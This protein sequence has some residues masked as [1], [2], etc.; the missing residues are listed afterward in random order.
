[1]DNLD[2]LAKTR[3]R[4]IKVI[5]S[6]KERMCDQYLPDAVSAELRSVILDNVNE[7]CDLAFD[8]IEAERPNPGVVFNE[9][10]LEKLEEMLDSRG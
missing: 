9:L 7:L 1:M 10:F 2:R 8:I 3:N 4:V 5:L 6:Y